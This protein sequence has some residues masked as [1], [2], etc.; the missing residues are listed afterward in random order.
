[1]KIIK[2]FYLY[3]FLFLASPS[4]AQITVIDTLT[5][6]E[7][8]NDYLLGEG[9]TA[10]NITFNGM[11][12]DSV[13]VT[14]GL[15]QGISDVIGFEEGVVMATDGAFDTVI[16]DFT[17]NTGDNF[18]DQDLLEISGQDTLLNCA[19]IEF[20]FETISDSV[21]FDYVFASDEYPSYTCSQFNDA[22][23]FFLSGPGLI[24]PFTDDAINIALVPNSDIPVAINTIN[25]GMA[26][27]FDPSPE[28]CDAANPNWVQDSQYF[29]DN[30][31][32]P[33]A[34]DVN[35]P[36]MTTTLTATEAI[37]CGETYHIK[38]AIGN[39]VD[40]SLDSGVFLEAG[41]FSAFGEI[42]SAFTPV[43][44]SDSSDVTQEEYDSIAVAG[45]TN[46]IIQLTRPACACFTSM[47]YSFS[48]EGDAVLGD[49]FGTVGTFPPDGF[50]V[51]PD[52]DLVTVTLETLDPFETDTLNIVFV[53]DYVTCE[54]FEGQTV[55]DIP[56]APPP[57]FDIFAEDQILICPADTPLV[58]GPTTSG[59]GLLPYIYDWFDLEPVEDE[60][61]RMFPAP[62]DQQEYTVRVTD[63]CEFRYDTTSF[64]VINSFPLDFEV[65]IDPFSDPSC[66][67]EPVSLQSSVSN[68]SPPYVYIWTDSH[69]NNYPG[70]D[71]IVAS[72]I[73]PAVEAFLPTLNVF[74]TAIDSCGREL[75]DEVQINYPDLDSLSVAFTPLFDNCPEAP[76][77][78]ESDASGGAGDYIY[79]WT[80]IGES[81]VTDGFSL[82][83]PT[84]YIDAGIGLNTFRISV[85]DRCH[86]L[87]QSLN[88]QPSSTGE[89]FSLG[90]D[91]A[92]ITIPY[93]KFDPLQNIITP[94]GDGQNE[95]LIIPG[96]EE[97]EDASVLVYDRWGKLIYE[98]NSYDAGVP[99]EATISQ[100]FS[101]DGFSDGTYM[102]IVNID[103]GECVTQGNLT[104][105]R[106]NE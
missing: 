56:I 34:G 20:D 95:V 43:F 96:I 60:Q 21:K 100:G 35:F 72:D 52:L 28:I 84:T 76:V 57:N 80:I 22:F 105:V 2:N 19:V 70:L 82:N 81:T 10:S 59:G 67:N 15:F 87:E 3:L 30:G 48:T 32:P 85:E 106:G 12:G 83:S 45:C 17:N 62:E 53:V 18:E 4:I 47:E 8:V 41:S 86:R 44:A 38:L 89:F 46:P 54:G 74:L 36:G 7:L 77:N 14:V 42:F 23:G 58:Y 78:L 102:F 75:S 24:G 40:Q 29:I 92:S 71:N 16:S 63:Q 50:D 37:Q 1:M 65:S 104:V 94:N 5:V 93:I 61:D 91:T 33:P 101:A 39:A 49:D 9:V 69:D 31:D 11:T 97:F 90:K 25:S 64:L 98:N 66:P 51:N 26:T 79:T 88:Y 13:Y 73:N 55:I 6:E 103:G 27:G 99:G 68:G